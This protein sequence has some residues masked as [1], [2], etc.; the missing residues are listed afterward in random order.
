MPTLV[1]S[2]CTV[3]NLCRHKG[4]TGTAIASDVGPGMY[5]F[6]LQ[7]MPSLSFRAQRHSM[8]S[9]LCSDSDL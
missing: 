1:T 4:S 6:V 7:M 3:M 9:I 5:M 2:G 8:P